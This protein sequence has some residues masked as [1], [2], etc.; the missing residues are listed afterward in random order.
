M[1][2]R[3]LV[4]LDDADP[5][6][7]ALEAALERFTTDEIIV[8]HVLDTTA[9]SHGV[10]GGAADGWLEAK[11][12]DAQALLDQAQALADPYDITLTTV[13]ESGYPANIIVNVAMERDVSHIVM[14]SH[15]RS[16]ISRILV[17]S[18]AEAVIRK[19]PMSVTVARK[20]NAD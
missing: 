15:G 8:L 9:S 10:G 2:D 14:G 13:I 18:V 20:P 1:T 12:A 4:P 11:K 5:A 7:T 17:G 16:G 6:W 19:A 3:I